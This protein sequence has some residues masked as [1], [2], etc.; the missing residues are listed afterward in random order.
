MERRAILRT[1][2]IA[3]G[4][5]L[6]AV[7]AVAA[8]GP[9]PGDALAAASGAAPLA[10]P[11]AG[12]SAA[13]APQLRKISLGV[14]VT[15]PNMVHLAPYIASDQGY[16]QEVGLD[17]D[18][19]NFEGGLQALR[20]GI[21]GGLDI[22]GTSADP[23]IAAAARGAGIKAIGTYAPKLSVVMVGQESI[24]S[25]ADLRGRRIGIQEV[26]G[27]N[28]VMSRAVLATAGMTPD[29][30][31]YVTV[32]T[33]GRVPALVANQIDAAILHADQY[34]NA[35]QRNP[36]FTV[37][38][39]LWEVLPKWWYSGYAVT[40]Q[41]IQQNRPM[42][43]DFET[44]I[45]RAGRFMY[46]NRDRTIEVGVQQTNE[47]RDAVERAYDD[48]AAGGI[49]AVNDGMPRDMI[50]YTLD[51]Q[52]EL[53]MLQANRRPTYDQIVDRSMADEALQ[54]LGGPWTDDPRWY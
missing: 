33:A 38:S 23:I 6:T 41:K 16:F 17:V 32:T 12:T 18:F 2:R 5:A 45:I 36:N 37:V 40:D 34:Y 26:G 3:L 7:V 39:R 35:I 4:L 29:D 47:P 13:A 46:Q 22:A 50:E 28:E 10:A 27:F 11:D 44:A 53:G 8:A 24:H 54:R 14:P 31:R 1:G 19:K 20:G 42:L 15:P 21:A 25:P 30:V 49:W 9:A 48:L 52:V 43:V 51:K